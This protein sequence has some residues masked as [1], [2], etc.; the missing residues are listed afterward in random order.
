MV[1]P[2]NLFEFV[3]YSWDSSEELKIIGSKITFS[4]DLEKALDNIWTDRKRFMLSENLF[5]ESSSKK[6]RFIDFRKK[7]LVPRN[8]IGTIHI[9]SNKAEYAINL[10]PK[11]FHK[12]NHKYTNKETESIFAHILWWLSGS[13]K[14]NYSTM[15]SSLGA[16]ES[17]FLEILVYIFSSYSLDIL[18]V[19]AY[20]YYETLSEEIE[21]VK[22]QIDFNNYVKNYAAG[23]K[24]KLPC[25]FDSFQYDNQFNRIVKYVSTLLKD[26]T[27]N[28]QTKRNLEEILFILDEVEYATRSTEDCDKIILN[29]IYTEFKTILDYCK[30]FLS[31]LSIYKWKDDYSVFA[32]LIPS[33]K[34][35]ENFIFS[36]LKQNANPQISNVSRSRPGRSHLVR[37][38]P[39]LVANRYSMINDI[40]VKLEDKSYILFDT[41]YKKIYNTRI[42]D[43]EDIDPVYNISQSDIY[44]MVSY[45][46]GSGISDLGLIYPALPFEP[47]KNELPVYEIQD[48]FKND[49]VIR[50][51]PFKVDIVHG[52][53]LELEVSGN[54]E[55][56][57][58]MASQKLIN[59]LND[60]VKTIKKIRCE[61][62]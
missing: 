57:F 31:S 48:E 9:R 12:E 55:N 5:Y 17:D 44:Q 59:Q 61:Y 23:N 2:I 3:N 8:W 52:D 30:M 37:Q 34:L 16:M 39:S 54:L 62:T 28:K 14:L 60:S 53:V 10:L 43:E 26:F 19:S 41:K 47:Q 45:A 4:D 21:T 51:Y 38:A 15:E 35:F 40:V 22:G 33:E 29:P 25:V 11:I 58:E 50:I 6:Q 7:E 42:Q 13:E 1:I 18:S 49:T 36:T 27:K 32:L 20:N 46:V 56:L 24:H